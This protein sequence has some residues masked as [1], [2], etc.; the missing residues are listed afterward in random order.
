MST[1]ESAQ[2]RRV[3][4][5]LI[6]ADTAF[7]AVISD[8]GDPFAALFDLGAPP[9]QPGPEPAPDAGFAPDFGAPDFGAPDFGNPGFTAASDFIF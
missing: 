8:P 2:N 1:E 5:I 6:D 4:I 3:E 7:G 9:P